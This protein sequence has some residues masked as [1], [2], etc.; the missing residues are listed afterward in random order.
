MNA[1]KHF[2]LFLTF[3]AGFSNFAGARTLEEIKA[4][5][6]LIVALDGQSPP[7][8][9]YKGKELV[10]LEVDLVN[11][12][13]EKLNLKVKWVVQPFGTLLTGLQQDRFDLIGTS[14]TITPERIKVVEFITPHYCNDAV[15]V[16]KLDGPKTLADLRGKSISVAVGAIYLEKLKELGMSK[17]IRAMPGEVDGL[18]ALLASRTEA[19]VTEKPI[20]IGAIEA[21]QQTGNLQIGEAVMQQ[22]NAMSVLKGNHALQQAINQELQAMINDG[23]FQELS[24]RYIKEDISCGL[25]N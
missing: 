5:G 3:F 12:I 2:F 11:K 14:H 17:E 15:I 4:S 9:Y 19:W 20:A 1:V 7:F 8:N 6:E 25:K 13:A 22:V 10:G 16:S 24:R 21:A 23:S 18:Q